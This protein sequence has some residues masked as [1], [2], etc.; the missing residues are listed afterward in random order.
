MWIIRCL[1]GIG[2]IK[3][4]HR[5]DQIEQL[6]ANLASR[7]AEIRNSTVEYPMR[8]VGEPAIRANP[9]FF[10]WQPVYSLRMI[11]YYH[12]HMFLHAP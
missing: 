11:Y 9:I 5:A 4:K 7:A 12:P 10:T 3:G 1:S 8:S 2:A 6:S